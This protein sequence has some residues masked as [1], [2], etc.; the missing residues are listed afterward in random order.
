MRSLLILLAGGFVV[1]C[2]TQAEGERMTA[3]LQTLRQELHAVK[4]G[5]DSDRTSLQKAVEH[6]EEKTKELEDTLEHFN[7]AARRTDADFGLQMDKIQQTIQEVSGK[8]EEA[9]FRLDRMEKQ[10]AN[11]SVQQAAS[12]P[13]TANNAEAPVALPNDKKAAR[14]LVSRLLDRG[15]TDKQHEDGKRLAHELLAKWPKDEGTSDVTRLA[16]GDRLVEDKLYQKAQVEYKKVLDDFPR[17]SRVDDAMF[18]IGQTFMLT[19]A[20]DDARVFFEELIRRYPKS[21]RVKEA[22]AKL[23]ELDHKKSAKAAPKKTK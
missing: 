13:S 14:D 19:N 17:G 2:V 7:T 9:A 20:P 18:K 16:L 8:L 23:V 6:A 5:V 11:G 12:A 10:T 15:A 21:P 3:D 1:G 22:K 4:S